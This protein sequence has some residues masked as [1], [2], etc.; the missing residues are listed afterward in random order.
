MAKAMSLRELRKLHRE[1]QTNGRR[2]FPDSF[3][4]KDRHPDN[5]QPRYCVYWSH[6]GSDKPHGNYWASL[7][8]ARKVME[9]K[10]NN[11]TFLGTRTIYVTG[12][13]LF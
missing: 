7:A 2:D 12:L 11:G 3:E 6:K 8:K 13:Y 9:E 1:E 4:N 5:N 10:V